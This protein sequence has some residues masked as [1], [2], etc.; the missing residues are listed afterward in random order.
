M[1]A[2]SPRNLLRV[3]FRCMSS[4]VSE[5]SIPAQQPVYLTL[6]GVPVADHPPKGEVYFWF[7]PQGVWRASHGD[8]SH[9]IDD[10]CARI[11]D[12]LAATIFDGIGNYYA[13]LPMIP[14]WV[15]N[16]GL[17]SEAP[18]S[19]DLFEKL[20]GANSDATLHKLLYLYDCRKLVSGI[21]E[22]LIE[23]VQ[24][25]GEFYKTLNLEELFYPPGVSPDGL[26]HIGS[27]V[28]AKLI[29]FIN[30]IY[31]RLHSLLDY[32]AKLAFEVEH[33]RTD[34]S[35]YPRLASR[36][37]LFGDRRRISLNNKVGTLFEACEL[38]T[39]T[40]ALRNLVIHEG[41]FDE[42]PKV[43]EFRENGVVQERYILMPDRESGRLTSHVNRSLFYGSEDKINL[44][45]PDFLGEFQKRL[46]LTVSETLRSFTGDKGSP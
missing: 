13:L 5:K 34:F 40:E 35:R 12:A 32:A 19:R 7:D 33:M 16:A 1:V 25:Q 22:A 44:R 46:L 26:R 21:Q 39:E 24:L 30:V 38:I 10:A 45:L 9:E 15:V 3:S 29:A 28:T 43:Y 42:Q 2:T 8:L 11:H 4:Q 20:V 31:V 41:F 27:P 14:E 6:P 23:V 18:I 37:K 36:N 17:N